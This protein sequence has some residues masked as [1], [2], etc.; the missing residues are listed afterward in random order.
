MYYINYVVVKY[1]IQSVQYW[2]ICSKEQPGLT[3]APKSCS[4]TLSVVTF[5]L[6]EL[7]ADFFG[8]I[9]LLG[10]RGE[11]DGVFHCPVDELFK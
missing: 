5:T 7:F 10:N 8:H 11:N 4:S 9:K 2:F 6:N 3:R 1:C